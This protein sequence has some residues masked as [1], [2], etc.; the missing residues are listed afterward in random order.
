[1]PASESI[2]KRGSGAGIGVICETSHSREKLALI[3]QSGTKGGDLI[4][5]PL[6]MCCPRSGF[7]PPWRDGN[8]RRLEW[9]PIANDTSALS[10]VPLTILAAVP[11]NVIYSCQD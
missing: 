7:L 1:M 8:D 5:K 11:G 2:D 4:C 10:R 9:F 6:E 3:P